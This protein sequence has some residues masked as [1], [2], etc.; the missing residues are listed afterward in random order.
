[1]RKEGIPND[2]GPSGCDTLILLRD[3]S[4]RLVGEKSTHRTILSHDKARRK[5]PWRIS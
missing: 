5:V 1:M 3:R 2:Q 4:A